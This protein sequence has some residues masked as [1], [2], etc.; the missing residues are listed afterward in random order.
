M[1]RELGAWVIDADRLAH[2]VVAHGTP[3]LAEVV[4]AFGAGVLTADGELDRPAMAR[5]VFGDEPARRRLEGIV[6]PRVFEEIRRCEDAAPPGSLV[7]HDLPLLAESGRADTFDAVVVVDAPVEVQVE[8]MV[9]QRGWT[10]DEA[11]SRLAAQS[12]R[13]D[14]LAVATHVVDN[15]G[16]LEDLRRQ[17]ETLFTEMAGRAG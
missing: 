3:G 12:S 9:Q 8:R 14:R 1:L 5:R 13:E 6:H 10:E 16:S 7:V 4:E 11:R 17:V 15:S 2:E